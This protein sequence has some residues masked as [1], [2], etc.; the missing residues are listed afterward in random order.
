[1]V[2]IDATTSAFYGFNNVSFMDN[3]SIIKRK[4]IS[5]F[6]LD[7]VGKM[8]L[9]VIVPPAMALS[10]GN[11]V[12]NGR[13][14]S[15]TS[16]MQL[17][18]RV[19]AALLYWPLIHLAGAATDDIALGVVVGSKGRGNLPRAVFD[20]RA[21]LLLL[22][23]A[24]FSS[25]SPNFTRLNV[26][27]TPT[28][29]AVKPPLAPPLRSLALPLRPFVSPLR[30][31]S[32]RIETTIRCSHSHSSSRCLASS[33]SSRAV[34]FSPGSPSSRRFHRLLVPRPVSGFN[35]LMSVAEIFKSRIAPILEDP[36]EDL[37]LNKI[38]EG[39]TRRISTCMFYSILAALKNAKKDG[40][41]KEI[42]SLQAVV[43]NAKVEVAAAAS[44]LNGAESE[45]SVQMLQF[46]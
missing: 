36:T 32:S 45:A 16:A 4:R 39:K 9:Y 18:E 7:V 6:K 34:I 27:L 43:E 24:G 17:I 14:L 2:A 3:F 42:T 46:Q 26:V 1:L 12:Q 38:L 44:Q 10:F 25:F 30:S 5:Y 33:S 11:D 15:L 19:P 13:N 35:I 22:L 31:H 28:L 40:I 21:T 41:G 20:I 37:S 8:P 23:I 29:E